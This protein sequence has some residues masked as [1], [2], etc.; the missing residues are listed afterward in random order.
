MGVVLEL[1]TP[2]VQDPGEAREIGP[3]EA[4]VLRQPL[5]GHGR[6]LQQGL[7]REALM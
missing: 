2:G 6:R 4:L 5:D 1:P 7:G 3:E